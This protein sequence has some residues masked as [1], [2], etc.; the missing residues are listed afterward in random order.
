MRSFLFALLFVFQFSTANALDWG[1]TGHRTVGQIAQD[2]LSKKASKMIATLL[3]GESLALVSN[4]ADN[5]KSDKK[6]N[7]Y[8]TW[9][10]VNLPLGA[11]YSLESSNSDG[12]II[13]GIQKCINVIREPSSS[14]AD[15]AFYLKM[16]VHFIGDLHQP[17]HIG[18]EEDKGGNDIKLT[19]FGK[20]TNLHRVWDSNLVEE[21]GMSY[22]ELSTES[23]R[24]SK[25]RK[26]QIMGGSP[27]DW[28]RE[29][30]KI[31]SVLYQDLPENGKLGYE[32]A[33]KYTGLMRDQI[34]KGGLRLAQ[35]LNEL[36]DK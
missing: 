22:S 6:F 7:S 8:N 28:L 9:H 10:Y 19:W 3:D 36:F 15:K 2:H 34:Q 13:Q 20:N 21:F 27:L 30:H 14:Q 4:Y 23:P 24:L 17:M 26:K 1:K 5:I 18:R 12:D 25:R 29:G 33:Y 32:Y 35:M 16:L 11:T 31:T